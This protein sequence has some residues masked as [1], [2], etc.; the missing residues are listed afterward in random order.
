MKISPTDTIN[1]HL[2]QTKTY[3]SFYFDVPFFETFIT[4]KIYRGGY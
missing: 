3:Y 4:D 2:K 1:L